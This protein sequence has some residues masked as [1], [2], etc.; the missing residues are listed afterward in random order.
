MPNT[1][2]GTTDAPSTPNAPSTPVAPAN[3]DAPTTPNV[4][5]TAPGTTDAPSTP[6]APANPDAP[7]TPNVPNTAPG[8]TD[9]LSPR[10]I[11]SSSRDISK[12]IP[13]DELSVSLTRKVAPNDGGLVSVLVP[14]SIMSNQQE[15]SFKLPKEVA[16]LVGKSTNVR[17]VVSDG[18]ELPSWLSFDKG[19]ESF[20]AASSSNRALP[21]RVLI[22][23]DAGTTV[24]NISVREAP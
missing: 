8:T 15:F 12:Q 16:N 11:P 5:N 17:A 21:I 1:A 22:N 9:N 23:T 2:P 14:K 10:N 7:T 24:M 20:S 19:N 3:L 13:Y 18:R 4:P 6:V